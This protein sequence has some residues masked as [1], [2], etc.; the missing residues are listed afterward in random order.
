L[1]GVVE[2]KG[3]LTSRI[4]RMLTRPIPKTAKL[5]IIGSLA[6][7]FFAA[8]LLPM[9]KAT[10]PPEFVIKG[11]VTD[12]QT[13]K[14]IAGAKVGDEKYAGGKYGTVTDSSGNYS[15]KTWYEEHNIKCEAAGYKTETKVLLTK[16]LGTERE[17][18]LDFAISSKMNSEDGFK[19]A[20]S[21]GVTVELIGICEYPPEGKKWW[22]P[23]GEELAETFNVKET[24]T[25]SAGG[26]QYALLY[27]IAG[28]NDKTF[29][30]DIEFSHG[31]G[32]LMVTDLQGLR[33][34]DVF[35]MKVFIDEQRAETS[36]KVNAA[37]GPWTVNIGYNGVG[38][39]STAKDGYGV[40][41]AIPQQ[42][43]KGVTL[44]VSDD[45][46]NCDRR[47]IA[48]DD[49]NEVHKGFNSAAGAGKTHQTNAIFSDITLDKIKEFQFQTRPQER[50]IFKNVSLRPGVKT[51][52][53]LQRDLIT[54][55][56]FHVVMHPIDFEIT[57]AKFNRGDLIEIT[58]LSGTA[59]DVRPGETY[60]V[61]G[62]Y[63]LGSRDNAMLHVYAT[64]G[65][66][67]SSQ[68]PI[69]K[70]GEGQ[71]TRTFTLLKEGD[72][73]LSFYPADGSESFGGVYF[74]QREADAVQ[75][76]GTEVVDAAVERFDIRPYPEG[77]L[78]T[79]TVS[80]RN[81]G[82]TESPK[83]G[84]NFYRGDPNEVKPMMHQAGPIKPGG[85]WHE[86][87][88]PFA[89]KEG[90]NEIA[91][92]LD[93]DNTLGESDRTNNEASMKVVVKDG[94]IV[95]KKVTL[96][97]AKVLKTELPGPV[98]FYQ[99]SRTVAEFPEKEDLSTPEAAY[100]SINRVS[101][102]GDAA[103][104]QRVSVKEIAEKLGRENK[105]GKMK[106]EPEWAK[107]LMNAKILEVRICNG[108]SAV[109]FAKLPQEFTS[110]TIRQ[111][112][113]IRH[114]KLEDGKWLNTGNDRV[115]TIEEAR[116]SF[117]NLCKN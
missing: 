98:Q 3:A 66:T 40:I 89:L 23:D 60:V 73:H 92:S 56:A 17:K 68:G 75:K 69:I 37:A 13:G 31:T 91:V 12:A 1:I 24:D 72:L 94:K 80:I 61:K 70:R 59:S 41:F 34:N 58:D 106:V 9:A 51:D 6:I 52:V 47:V 96:P 113:D 32:S 18:V 15:Y 43:D 8:V 77:G 85:L 76:T 104:W 99:V 46:N 74:A 35:G 109:V 84:V 111:P 45:F 26:K 79:V 25:I 82:R 48:I 62:R 110:E 107:V 115:W 36:V 20:L 38:V 86:G 30:A 95:E 10:P 81:R 57:T 54:A 63:K 97:A 50:V 28:P 88:M 7:I 11:T 22:R 117:D 2:S 83:F 42:T 44:V 16:V 103:G 100:A 87:A 14:P 27:K 67:S 90:T 19:A 21:N 102:S 49:N 93:P 105:N 78:Y 4:K 33:I 112:I 116:Q 114:L 53:K 39:L 108:N 55:E 71:F 64:N 5:G 101:A 65:E 29:W